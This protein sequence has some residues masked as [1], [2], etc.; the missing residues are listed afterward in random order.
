MTESPERLNADMLRQVQAYLGAR[1]D[2]E[3]AGA[4]HPGLRVGDRGLDRAR[5]GH[6]GRD[7][8]DPIAVLGVVNLPQSFQ[9]IAPLVIDSMSGAMSEAVCST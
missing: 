6:V 2:Q 9:V 8:Q 3:P 7:R 5:V 1:A 4:P